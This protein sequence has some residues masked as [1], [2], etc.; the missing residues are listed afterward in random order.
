MKAIS[1]RTW[2]RLGCLLVLAAGGPTP[3][4]ADTSD[5]APTGF[6]VHLRHETQASP[7]QLYEALARI[8]QWW[9]GRHT[10]S[11][12]AS[13]LSLAVQAGGCFCERWE[14]NSVE[15]ARVVNVV[16][17]RLLRLS[18]ALGPLQALAVEG[19]LS[20]AI[21]EKDGRTTLEVSYR[22]A[23]PASAALDRL[24][25][26]VD[27]VIADQAKRLVRFAETGRPE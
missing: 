20:F 12:K 15:H 2:Q 9:N 22:V 27:G 25:G 16:E 5:V 19:I 17:G 26:P 1:P 24:A 18:G 14:R 7:R 11:G 6:V 23:G 4:S 13:N 8:D 10:Y 21:G 3:A